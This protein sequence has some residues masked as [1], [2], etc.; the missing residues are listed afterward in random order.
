MKIS[1]RVKRG[2]TFCSDF[3]GDHRIL[4]KRYFKSVYIHLSITYKLPSFLLL[5]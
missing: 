5:T 1:V 2:S 3:M 4:E